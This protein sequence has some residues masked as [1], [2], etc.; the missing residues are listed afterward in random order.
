MVNMEII[1]KSVNSYYLKLHCYMLFS[2]FMHG[3][4]FSGTCV[5]K[6]VPVP[7]LR[8]VVLCVLWADEL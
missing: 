3:L 4:G 5:K 1:L 8:C 6:G 2:L 7:K